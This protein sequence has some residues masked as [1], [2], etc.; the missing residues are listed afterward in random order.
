MVEEPHEFAVRCPNRSREIERVV[1]VHGLERASFVAEDD[2]VIREKRHA[3]ATPVHEV[4]IPAEIGIPPE[5]RIVHGHSNGAEMKAE[6]R[7]RSGRRNRRT[8]RRRRDL[9]ESG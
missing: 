4:D 2:L 3:P 7:Q 6:A 1:P 8:R 9:C 5:P